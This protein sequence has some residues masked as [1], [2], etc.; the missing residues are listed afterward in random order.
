VTRVTI[1]PR[2]LAV[3]IP[4]LLLLWLATDL[5]W[6]L[7]L[8]AATVA[9]DVLSFGGVTGIGTGRRHHR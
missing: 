9:F 3:T 6:T 4:P 2:A 7:A 5:R 8:A 1:H